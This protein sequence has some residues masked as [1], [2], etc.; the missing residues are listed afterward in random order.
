MRFRERRPEL[1]AVQAPG[2][3]A[4]R[5]LGVGDPRTRRHHVHAARAQ[6]G[7]APQAVVVDDLA[8]VQPGDGLQPDVRVR[9]HVHRLAVA[10][11]EWPEAIEK[12]PRTDEAPVPD[13]QGAG[14]RQTAQRH[15]AVR[16]RLELS[17]AG[18]ERDALL[19]G[20]DLRPFRHGS[21]PPLGSAPR[22]FSTALGGLARRQ[23][24][25]LVATARRCRPSWPTPRQWQPWSSETSGAPRL[26][27]GSRGRRARARR[28][29]HVGTPRRRAA[30]TNAPASRA[31]P[32]GHARKTA[33]GRAPRPRSSLCDGRWLDSDSRLIPFHVQ[34]CG[35]GATSRAPMWRSQGLGCRCGWRSGRE[36]ARQRYPG[37]APAVSARLLHPLAVTRSNMRATVPPAHEFAHGPVRWAGGRPLS[38]G[39]GPADDELIEPRGRTFLNSALHLA[40]F[41]AP[42]APCC[43]LSGRT[44][45]TCQ[46]A[47]ASNWSTAA[48]AAS[49]P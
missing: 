45:A 15:F 38:P 47:L 24:R 12:A 7:G 3:L 4:R 43:P 46:T 39:R 33:D 25:P 16:I 10:E 49:A 32:S 37:R 17:P 29:R 8:F 34:R 14:D 31:Q 11:R 6:D 36:D 13:R 28:T 41:E 26:L 30:A 22:F 18:A 23:P 20:H 42:R 19:R 35:R 40:P 2:V 44:G 27:R 5:L 1:H 21:S 48:S 9:R